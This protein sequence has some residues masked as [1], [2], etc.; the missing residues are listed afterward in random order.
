M[1]AKQDGA[2]VLVSSIGSLKG[3]SALGA[4]A[5]SKAA[6]NQLAR[7]LALELGQFH[8]RVN[9][10]LPGLVKTDFA[11]ALWGTPQGQERIKSFPMGRVGEPEDIAPA[12]VYLA[13]P[14]ARWT[15]GQ[16]LVVD[17]GATIQG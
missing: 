7:N 10:V 2:I 15:T 17:G 12:A 6:M 13:S 3:S 9:A 4:Y 5:M 11:K 14:G 16:T 1:K 8:I